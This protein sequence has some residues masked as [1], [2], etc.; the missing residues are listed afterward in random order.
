MRQPRRE[1]GWDAAELAMA[2]V[3][4]GRSHQHR[5]VVLR[6]ELVIRESA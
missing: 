5:Q 4:E 3:G 6:P 1:L 2:E